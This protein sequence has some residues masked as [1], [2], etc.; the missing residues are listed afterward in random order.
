MQATSTADRSTWPTATFPSRG[1]RHEFVDQVH[2]WNRVQGL[3][4][5]EM[6]LLEDGFSLRF[7]SASACRHNVLRLIDA[8]GGQIDDRIS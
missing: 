4:R 8:C 1:L 2:V 7:F 6:A 5:I 3:P